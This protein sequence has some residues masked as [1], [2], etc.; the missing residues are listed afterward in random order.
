MRPG[1]TCADAKELYQLL[2]SHSTASE[3][4]SQELQEMPVS[5]VFLRPCP[6]QQPSSPSTSSPSFL[7]LSVPVFLQNPGK[8]PVRTQDKGSLC[9]RDCASK[10]SIAWTP[11]AG[12]LMVMLGSL[13]HSLQCCEITR[14]RQLV[15]RKHIHFHFFV[16]ARGLTASLSLMEGR[17]SGVFR[18]ARAWRVQSPEP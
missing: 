9:Q 18:H 14:D 8:I 2:A 12:N 15:S 6:P 17:P 5:S 13:P 16:Q 1:H 4:L 11:S 10:R 7:S 3:L